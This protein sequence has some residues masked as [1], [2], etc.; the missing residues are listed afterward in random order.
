MDEFEKTFGADPSLLSVKNKLTE[1]VGEAAENKTAH[2][3]ILLVIAIIG[4]IIQIMTYCRSRGTDDEKLKEYLRNPNDLSLF[5]T[6]RLRRDIRREA[7]KSGAFSK[8]KADNAVKATF[9]IGE[10]LSDDEIAALIN[11]AV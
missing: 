2:F 5:Q 1:S 4:L 11:H 6:W 10:K 9:D 7:V 3:T 8:L